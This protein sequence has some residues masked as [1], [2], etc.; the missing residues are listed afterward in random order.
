MENVTLSLQRLHKII[1]KKKSHVLQS[2]D[3]PRSDRELLIRTRWLEEI[4]RGWYLAIRPDLRNGDSTAWFANF[5]DFL[6][7]FLKNTKD[8]CLS[9]E[10]SLDVHLGSMQIPKQVVVT[11][12]KG[13]SGKVLQL[14]FGTSLL[15]YN[16]PNVPEDIE[17]KKG[18]KVMPLA[19]ALCRVSPTFFQRSP[20]EAEIALR[21]VHHSSDLLRYLLT[22]QNKTAAERIVGAYRFLKEERMADD[23][24]AGLSELGIKIK[25][26]NPFVEEKPLI[27]VRVKSP[28][29]ARLQILWNQYREVIISHFPKPPGLPKNKEAYLKKVQ[30]IYLHDAY[31]SLSIEGYQVSKELIDKVRKAEWNPDLDP[32]DRQHRD[33]LAARGYYE[34]FLLVKESVEK[35]LEKQLPGQVVMQDLQKWYQ[36]LFAPSVMVGILEPKDLFGYRRH[37]VYIRNSRHTPPSKEHI[38][39]CMEAFF[40]LLVKRSTLAYEPSWAISFLYTYTHSWTEMEGL[41][42]SL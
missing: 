26:V 27:H 1:E 32:T 3:I 17:E 24:V 34:A 2:A 29:V 13:G 19:A 30:S 36:K 5:W 35:I 14:P 18:L 28:Y 10:N 20:Q 33:A 31:N 12:K 9:A 41:P 22:F 42:D 25:E 15:V 16:D 37:Q 39:D 21:M 38:T 23:L 8:Y 4:I 40:Q 6:S 7:R 11:V